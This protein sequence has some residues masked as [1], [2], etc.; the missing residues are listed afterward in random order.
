MENR[1]RERARWK[2][3]MDLTSLYNTVWKNEEP[4][5]KKNKQ[6]E[7]KNT[8][9]FFLNSEWIECNK[10]NKNKNSIHSYYINKKGYNV[11]RNSGI[12]KFFTLSRCFFRSFLTFWFNEQNKKK[13]DHTRLISINVFPCVYKYKYIDDDDETLEKMEPWNLVDLD[14]FFSGYRKSKPET[15]KKN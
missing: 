3:H 8:E 15:N 5:K 2:G 12:F 14:S 1:Y 4:E 7:N 10:K 6:N 9:S 11:L 13:V